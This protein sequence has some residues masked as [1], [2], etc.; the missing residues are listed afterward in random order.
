MSVARAE[1]QTGLDDAD[2]MAAIASGDVEG[3][4]AELYQRHGT[5]LYR[6]GLSVLGNNSGLAE[7]MVQESFIRLW[8]NAQRFDP[9]RAKASTYLIVIARSV[10]A[11]IARRPSSRPHLPFDDVQLTPDN[12]NVD[13]VLQSLMIREAMDSLGPAHVQVLRLAHDEDLT[14]V[15]IA[16]RLGLP[17]GTVKTRMFHGMRA[18]RAALTERGFDAAVS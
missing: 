13:R 4:I 3:P 6:Y 5:R 17:L 1:E 10:A 8:R 16:Q 14:Q 9:A 7:E 11:D 2:L 15:Q 18:L 12:D